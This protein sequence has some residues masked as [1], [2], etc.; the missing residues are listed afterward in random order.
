M[1]TTPTTKPPVAAPGATAV[2]LVLGIGLVGLGV[3]AGRDALIAGGA[4]SGTPWITAALNTFDGMSAQSWMV[5][6]GAMLAAVGILLVLTAVKPR[7]R[8]HRALDID[9]AWLA[10]ADIARVAQGAAET[11]TGTAA[12][13]VSGSRRTVTVNVVPLA[14]YDHDELVNAVNTAVG[15]S[16]SAL[17]SAP[18]LRTRITTQEQK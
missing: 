17:A 13:N 2:A 7:K 18:R 6:A 15:Q 8:T 5:P 12:V 9:D 14:G 10:S 3:I 11:V 1:S 16:F 4:L